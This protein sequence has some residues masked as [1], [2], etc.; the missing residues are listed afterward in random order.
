LLT[1]DTEEEFDWNAPFSRTSTGTTHVRAFAGFQRLCEEIGARPIWLV[2]WPI[3]SDPLAVEVLGDAARRDAADIGIHL[4]PWVNPPF[5]EEVTPFNSYAGNLPPALEAAKFMALRERIE[6]AFG[7]APMIYRAG[8]YGLG[9]ESARMLAREGIAIDSSVRPSFDYRADGGPNYTDYPAWPWWI[10]EERKLLE[11]PV[12][13]VR[14]G[15]LRAAPAQFGPL[16]HRV[17]KLTGVLARTRLLE[18]IPL[19]PEGVSIVAAKRGIDTALMA[20]LPLLVLSLHSPTLEPGHS[21]YARTPHDVAAVH[22]WLRAIYGHLAAR[23]VRSA[24]IADILA[25]CRG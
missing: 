20:G 3:A 8:R 9:P 21:P 6:D 5:D 14:A 13:T 4:H 25:A 2:D 17:P 18:R 23:G 1:I 12:T 10:D 7:I 22:D 24:G 19:T 11:L 15:A 16:A